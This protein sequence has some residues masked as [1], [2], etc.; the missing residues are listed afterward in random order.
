ME[1]CCLSLWSLLHQTI[2]LASGCLI[3][4]ESSLPSQEDEPP[5]EPEVCLERQPDPCIL[6]SQKTPLRDSEHPDCKSHQD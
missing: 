4:T 5:P 2:Q 3:D 6:E 1:W